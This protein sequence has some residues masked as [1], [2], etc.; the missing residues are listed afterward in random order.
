MLLYLLLSQIFFFFLPIV[1]HAANLFPK[2]FLI[3]VT[4]NDIV[5]LVIDIDV[6]TIV[7]RHN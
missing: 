3:V 5:S 2:M 6:Y 4:I 7:A 1:I